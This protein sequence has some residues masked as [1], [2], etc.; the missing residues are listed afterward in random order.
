MSAEPLQPAVAEPVFLSP[1]SPRSPRAPRRLRKWV[2]CLVVPCLATT[3]LVGVEAVRSA[4]QGARSTAIATC[5]GMAAA[6]WAPLVLASLI[7]SC[8]K[9]RVALCTQGAP[10][11]RFKMEAALYVWAVVASLVLWYPPSVAKPP[12][13]LVVLICATAP[14][15]VAAVISE[16]VYKIAVPE[17]LRLPR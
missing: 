7:C 10:L 6:A 9:F 15:L 16:C 8:S 13:A 11:P 14:V 4:H 3:L 1:A 5:L 2:Y 17:E 12:L